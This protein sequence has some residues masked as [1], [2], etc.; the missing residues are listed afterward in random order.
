MAL[1]TLVYKNFLL[2]RRRPV[3]TCFE[4]LI[5]IVLIVLFGYLKTLSDIQVYPKG[6]TFG[7]N[8]FVPDAP[9]PQSKSYNFFPTMSA[10]RDLK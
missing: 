10:L 3:G 4:L 6:W 7:E 8:S 1:G 9:P 5:P 2:K